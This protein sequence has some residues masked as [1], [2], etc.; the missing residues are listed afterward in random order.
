MIQLEYWA[1][2]NGN[3]IS[4]VREF[5]NVSDAARDLKIAH[6]NR[7]AILNDLY[8]KYGISDSPLQIFVDVLRVDEKKCKVHKM[9]FKHFL[10]VDDDVI[11]F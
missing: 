9:K 10:L 3:Y 8:C 4:E 1:F 2:I 6:S 11:V 7:Y 5:D